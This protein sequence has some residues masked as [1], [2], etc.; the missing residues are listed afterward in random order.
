[1]AEPLRFAVLISGRGS[2]LLALAT[3]AAAGRIAGQIVLVISDQPQAG[4]LDHA[5]RFGIPTAVRP[6]ARGS[7][8]AAWSRELDAL[9]RAHGVELIVLAGF[10]RIL[11]PDFVGRWPGRIL[12]IHPSLLPRHRGLHTHRRVLEAGDP[13][14]GC[15]VHFVSPEL[16]AGPAVIQGRFAVQPDATEESLTARVQQLEHIIYPRAVGWFAGGRLT[17]VDSVVQLDGRPL[18]APVIEDSA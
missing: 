16:D 8:R 6:L 12:N 2:N 5:R 11:D 13:V 4:G 17:L 15:T 10:M 9:L 1:M 3:A 7:D 18:P 14:H